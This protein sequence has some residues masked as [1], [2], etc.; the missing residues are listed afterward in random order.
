MRPGNDRL[1]DLFPHA[2]QIKHGCVSQII[3]AVKCQAALAENPWQR[4]NTAFEIMMANDAV[5]KHYVKE[6]L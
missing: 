1:E 5:R 6:N 2:Q 3:E 4:T